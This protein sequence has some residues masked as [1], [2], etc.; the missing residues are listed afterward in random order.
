[1]LVTCQLIGYVGRVANSSR[2][3]SAGEQLLWRR[4]LR[5]NATLL[6]VLSRELQDAGLS[7]S[8]YQVLVKLTDTAEG[9]VRVTDL[10]R[11]V[12]W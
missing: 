5:L 1:M 8:D 3:L 9:R 12:N 10:A 7:L 2:W 4:W 11:D 6:G